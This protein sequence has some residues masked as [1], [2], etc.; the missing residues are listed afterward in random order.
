MMLRRPAKRE[1]RFGASIPTAAARP[2]WP[3]ALLAC[4]GTDGA[5]ALG[6]MHVLDRDGLADE[7]FLKEKVL[8][9][10][11]LKTQ[12][13]PK[14]TPRETERLTGVPA[15]TVVELAHAYGKARA[16]FIRL[17]SGQSRYRNG[18]MTSRLI[19]CLPAV[20]GAWGKPGGGLLTS[21]GASKA[22]QREFIRHSD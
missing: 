9:W 13:L 11:A 10:E 21:A 14:Y 7:T 18:A 3:T 1:L 4:V 19:T 16:P 6:M 17:G 20:V 12:V 22:Y 2:I 15:D 5:L 8:G